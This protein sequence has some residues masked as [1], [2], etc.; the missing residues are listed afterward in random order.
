M[1]LDHYVPS[2]ILRNF[3]GDGGVLWVLDKESGNCYEKKGGKRQRYEAFAERNYNPFST[4]VVLSR[5][6]SNA[7]SVVAKLL[8]SAQ[9]G[10]EPA[11]SH[12][13]KAHLCT[14]LFVQ[15]LRI[16]RVKHW[17][18]SDEWEYDGEK[19]TL[20]QMFSS[21]SEDNYPAGLDA[22]AANSDVIDHE[23]LEKI[24]WLRM[25]RMNLNVATIGQVSKGSLL[26]SDEPCLIRRSL[27]RS[28]D[29]VIMPLSRDVF[30][31]L[32]QPR[33]SPGGLH[34]LDEKRVQALNRQSYRKAKRFIAGPSSTCLERLHGVEI[35]ADQ[36]RDGI[37]G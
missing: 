36:L 13:E 23:H 6:E 4:E 5:I 26:V 3:A 21:L 30:L 33:D 10:M 8:G 31:E 9:R 32:S 11:L 19:E 20:W 27:V 14:F 1:A 16:P 15:A 2:F 22:D 34:V 35:W 12:L 29:R 28:G 18:M 7:S 25:M 24:F 37:G 17:V